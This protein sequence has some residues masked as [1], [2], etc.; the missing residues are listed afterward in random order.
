MS[1]LARASWI[2]IYA[3]LLSDWRTDVEARKS[4]VDRNTVIEGGEHW[5]HTEPQVT[6]LKKW[7]AD[8][9]PFNICKNDRI[10]EPIKC[11]GSNISNA[12][13]IT[14]EKYKESYFDYKVWES[15]E[16]YPTPTIVE[17]AQAL[18]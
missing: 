16:Y 14:V 8:S 3:E 10:I 17:A 11:N 5:F 15:S 1:R 6:F 12:I 2:E 4:L 18:Y 13:D 7:V 9:I